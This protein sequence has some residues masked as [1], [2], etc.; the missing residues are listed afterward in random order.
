[1]SELP[2][3][4]T[5]RPYQI[6]A[7]KALTS[8]WT[9]PNNRLAVV[10]PTGAG[11]TVVFA[12]LISEMLDQLNGRRALV[13]AH[14]EELIQQA[15]A[16]VRAVR[17]DLRVGI[18]KA[19]RDDHQDADVIVAS[20]QTLA[21]E[22]RRNAIRDIG[23]IIVDECHHAAA[24]T[25]LDVL[26]HFG[27]WRAVPVAG[28]TAT[29]TRTDGGLA[30]VWE[31]VVF[32]LD[33]LEMIEDG[34]LCDVRGKRIIVDGLDLDAVKTRHG[35]LQDGQ[36]GQALD[37][38]GAA[39]VVAEAYRQHAPG[40]PG[41]VFTPTVDTAQSMAEA[42]TAAGIP[43]AAIWGDMPKDDRAAVLEQYKAGTVQVLT[44]CMV[45][46]EGFDAPW[47]SCVVIARPTK[48]AGLYCQMAGR[49]L[50]LF[51]GKKDALILDVMGASTRHKLASIVDLTG[52]EVVMS[53]E[54]QTLREAVREAEEKERRRLD[55]SRIQVEE[56]DLFHGS[57]TRWLKTDSGVWFIPVGDAA[58]VF[59]VRNPVDRTYWLRRFDT[60][61]GV[62]G[63][64]RDV[65]LPLADAKAWL[66]QQARAMGSRWLATRAAPW[67][68]KPASVKQ[69]NFCRANGI[70][71]PHGST[72]GE[73]SDL[74]AVHQFTTILNRLSVAAAA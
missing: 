38:S 14:R 48:S 60:N 23:L 2:E 3:T 67:R 70:A 31:E 25:Y 51:E 56:I 15:A 45:L 52:R 6:E 74:Q 68:N 4:F 34:Y 36:L 49:A 22:R 16:K 1:M 54:E 63:P 64:K 41:V 32:T 29:M 59:L 66:E 71:V 53:D 5:P 61:N 26:E 17:P 28:F 69:L 12:N 47:T 27:A 65:P 9:G 57:T 18:V 43:A 13:I 62:V 8:S 42:F 72:A 37:E 24:T 44:N 21:V 46:T 19:Q 33:I 20:I 73:V 40:R 35:D 10:L 7:I 58:F 39:K 50:R 30:E 11:K 55:L